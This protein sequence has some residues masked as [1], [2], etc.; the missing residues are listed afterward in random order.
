MLAIVLVLVVVLVLECC[1][2][3]RRWILDTG[4]WMKT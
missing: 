1:P 3:A 2:R 4:C